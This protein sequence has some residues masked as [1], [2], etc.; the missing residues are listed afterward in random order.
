MSIFTAIF[1]LASAAAHIIAPFAPTKAN[2]TQAAPI[3]FKRHAPQAQP[4]ITS[5][6]AS[7]KPTAP[8][9]RITTDKIGRRIAYRRLTPDA[10]W[11]RIKLSEAEARI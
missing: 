10:P 2:N 3:I 7:A 4:V 11:K 5:P 6:V 9:V 8:E 1:E